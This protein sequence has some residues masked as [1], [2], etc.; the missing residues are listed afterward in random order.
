MSDGHWFRN[1]TWT[2][3][4]STLF[5]SNLRRARDKSQ[6][7]RIQASTLAP[8][9]PDVALD[10][11]DRYFSVGDRFADAFA[12]CDRATAL[13]TLGRFDDAVDAYESALAR[14][15]EFPNAMSDAFVELP[16][17]VATR[18]LST[19][20]SRALDVLAAFEA[21]CVFP[22]QRF[23]HRSA[24]ALISA[25]EGNLAAARRYASAALEASAASSSGFAKHQT[26]GLVTSSYEPL[27]AKMRG[28]VG[29]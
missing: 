5:E 13:I 7:L 11:L 1:T 4:T 21:R 10:L 22:I 8:L 2:R 24:A 3:A 18:G 25:G 27:I 28:L 26:L 20:Y 23:K 14:E 19:R 9:V 17:L 29:A 12:F 6:Y 16:Y 15:S